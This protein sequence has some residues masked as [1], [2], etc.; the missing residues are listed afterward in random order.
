MLIRMTG[1]KARHRQG[2]RV[3]RQRRSDDK[4]YTI[5]FLPVHHVVHL[6]TL[7]RRLEKVMGCWRTPSKSA[8]GLGGTPPDGGV[9]GTIGTT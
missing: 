3:L 7:V 5:H 6:R 9:Y 2:L 1:A 8:M 4:H